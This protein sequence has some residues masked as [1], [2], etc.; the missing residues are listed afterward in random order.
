MTLSLA[1]STTLPADKTVRGPMPTSEQVR[2]YLPI[3]RH[4]V[5]GFLRRLPPSVLKDDL[6]AAGNYGMLDALRKAPADRGPA[7]EWYVRLRI[8]G[9]ILDELRAQDWLTREGRR[10]A[11]VVADGADGAREAAPATCTGIIRIDDLSEFAQA[12]TMTDPDAA[13]GLDVLEQSV[14]RLALANAVGQLPVR[15]QAIVRMHYFMDLQL[16]AIATELGLSQP[17]VSQ[18]HARAITK[19]KSL[20]E[21]QREEAA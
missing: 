11:Q 7:F 18:L 1:P 8:R 4:I 5:A 16:K 12:A 2:D 21:C 10:A 9:A 17:R 15:E 14:N 6:I 20:L 19:L 13:T 3:V